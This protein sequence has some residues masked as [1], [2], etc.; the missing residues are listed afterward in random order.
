MSMVYIVQFLQNL[1]LKAESSRDIRKPVNSWPCTESEINPRERVNTSGKPDVVC[2]FS[3]SDKNQKDLIGQKAPSY[4]IVVK[5]IVVEDDRIRSR[6]PS[7]ESTVDDE[8]PEHSGL[9]HIG[10][11]LRTPG[12]VDEF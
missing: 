11:I 10:G 8:S 4:E 9:L 3:A 7:S 2:H 1:Q 5:Q 12:E 6:V